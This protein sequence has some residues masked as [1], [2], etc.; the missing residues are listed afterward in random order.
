[1]LHRSLV[2]SMERLFAH[3]IE[4][5][6]GAFPVWYAPVQ[7]AVLPVGQD[8][9]AAAMAFAQAAIEAGLRAEVA[10]EG[11]LAS[12][13]RDAARARIPYTGVIGDREAAAGEVSLR[14]RDGRDLSAMPVGAALR[15]IR[16][17]A[18]P[19]YPNLGPHS[20]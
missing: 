11:S 13:V 19:A 9:A 16:D 5:H 6:E 3:L 7:L 4:V 15:L 20:P 2:G 8:Q 10:V 1:M 12:R 17:A 18:A 14:L